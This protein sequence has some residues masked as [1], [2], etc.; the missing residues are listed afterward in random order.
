MYAWGAHAPPPVMFGMGA[1]IRSKPILLTCLRGVRERDFCAERWAMRAKR[2]RARFMSVKR[3]IPMSGFFCVGFLTRLFPRQ[4]RFHLLDCGQAQRV[5]LEQF[6]HA[7][8][9][10]L[11]AM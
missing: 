11:A 4:A 9:G 10:S 3:L 5:K 7:P 1:A 8:I 2:G 6:H